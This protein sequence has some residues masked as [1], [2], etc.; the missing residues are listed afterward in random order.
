MSHGK[1]NVVLVRLV[2]TVSV[3]DPLLA[4][5]FG[6]QL[7]TSTA[8]CAVIVATHTRI[9]RTKPVAGL[10]FNSQKAADPRKTWDLRYR[11]RCWVGADRDKVP[12]SCSTPARYAGL[13]LVMLGRA[14]ILHHGLVRRTR[15]GLCP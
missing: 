2:A 6:C 10:A 11:W 14:G 13:R 15:R 9:S 5:G 4:M 3:G 7:P 12:S 1:K 8:N